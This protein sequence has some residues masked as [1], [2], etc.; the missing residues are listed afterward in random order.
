MKIR[1]L[2]MADLA[3]KTVL[4][5]VDYNVPIENGEIGDDTR[6]TATIPTIKF[7]QQKNAK[8]VLMSHLGRPEEDGKE[9]LQMDPIAKKLSTLLNQPV[10]K[11]NHCVGPEVETAVK[12]MENGDIVLLENTRFY[13]EEEN[14]DPKFSE[15]LAKL[16]DLFVIDSFGTAHRKHA[17]TYGIAAHLPTFAGLLMEK[18]ITILSEVM[19]NTA[20]PLTLIMGGAK[21]E[22]K[23]G[24]I[25]NFLAD[26][27]NFLLGGGL[28]NTFIAAQGF[29]VGS[30]LYESDKLDLARELMLEAEALKT[31]FY[32]PEDAIV[33]DT[34]EDTSPTLDLPLD[35]ITGE[36]KI[37]DLGIKSIQTFEEV[38][39]HSKT[40]IW[41]GPMG[42]FEKT[43]FARGTE[44]IT[45]AIAANKDAKTIIGGGDTIEAIKKFGISESSFTHVST[46]GGAMLQ[47]L[48]GTMLP[49]VEIVLEK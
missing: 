32:L 13:P 24:L 4:L 40:I 35:N 5:R 49:G 21:I 19:T 27:D 8:I 45:K 39:K 10:T 11:L 36:M 17:T 6:I 22:T 42:L 41:N 48:E 34:I 20:H 18:E 26:A 25:R 46:G 3:N 9:G 14:N 23:I 16:A 15:N 47:F 29:D 37:L 33:A 1:T 38:I 7:I 12:N 28:A 44:H 2:N 43:P 31:V 30:S